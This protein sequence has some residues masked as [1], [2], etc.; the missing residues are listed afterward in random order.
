MTT[1]DDDFIRFDLSDGTT[2][3]VPLVA[4]GL[5]WPPPE[6]LYMDSETVREAT[7]QDAPW[8]VMRQV[9]RSQITDELRAGMTHV[10]RGAEYEH[11][12]VPI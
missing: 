6:R 9:R 10:C 12:V 7:D 2:P 11:E 4:L 8:E 5:E 3:N 1:F